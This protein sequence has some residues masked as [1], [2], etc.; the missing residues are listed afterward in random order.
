MRKFLISESAQMWINIVLALYL[1]IGMMMGFIGTQFISSKLYAVSLLA[2]II[3]FLIYDWWIGEEL[4]KRR[5][6]QKS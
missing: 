5:K 6:N 2:S 1:F 4:Y 3:L